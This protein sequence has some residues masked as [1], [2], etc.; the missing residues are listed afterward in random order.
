M[1]K[2]LKPVP[3][4]K[5]GKGLSKLP[6]DVRNKMGFFGTGGAVNA[7][8]EQAMTPPPKARVRAYGKGGGVNLTKSETTIISDLE[9]ARKAGDYYDYLSPEEKAGIGSAIGKPVLP[10]K[11]P[12]QK[13]DKERL[14]EKVRR[15]GK[16]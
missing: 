4:G 11:K 5:K 15:K 1:K 13:T 16:K 2:D 10:S 6:K 7:H 12:K 9:G 8:K 3:K 14:L